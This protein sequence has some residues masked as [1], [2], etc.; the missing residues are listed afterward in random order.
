M[1]KTREGI[2]QMALIMYLIAYGS[3]EK[4]KAAF[5][6]AFSRL[7]ADHKIAKDENEYRAIMNAK[8]GGI[9]AAVEAI[10]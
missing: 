3:D 8:Y 10:L 6:L 2:E 9:E 1:D 5:R 7:L 4:T